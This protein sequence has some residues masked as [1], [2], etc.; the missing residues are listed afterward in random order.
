[1]TTFLF[2]CFMIIHPGSKVHGAIM[3]PTWVLWATDG[4]H[5]GPMN[6]AIRM[7]KLFSGGRVWTTHNNTDLPGRDLGVIY[8]QTVAS[9]LR[10]CFDDPR[11]H[12]VVWE[13][14]RSN[15]WPKYTKGGIDNIVTRDCCD[16]FRL[17][18]YTS[19]NKH[20]AITS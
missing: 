6:L 9:C 16:L 3:G 11:C 13:K 20:C 7:I 5:V 2:Q 15:C 19:G 4:P 14:A 1:M 12:D 18:N 8:N 17:N 10:L